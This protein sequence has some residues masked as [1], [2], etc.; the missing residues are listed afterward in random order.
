VDG[1]PENTA[2]AMFFMLE[3]LIAKRLTKRIV[4][5]RLQVGHTH[6]DID[7]VFG[8]LWQRL[9]VSSLT[10]LLTPLVSLPQIDLAIA[11]VKWNG[12]QCTA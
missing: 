5:S 3:L 12:F 10:I 11:A 2:K 6:C 4:L 9:R 8:R 7:A 1:G